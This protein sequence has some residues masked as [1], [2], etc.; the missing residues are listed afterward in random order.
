MIVLNDLYDY[1]LKIYQDTDKF[2]FSL[3]SILIAE[4]VDNSK[5]NR[6]IL[7]LCTG[8]A[9]I[10]LILASYNPTTFITG[11]EIQK[12]IYD[13]AIKSI[14]YNKLE[15]QINLLNINAKDV[16]NYFP[17][18]NFDAILCNPPF[19]KVSSFSHINNNKAKAIARH[20]LTITLKDIFEVSS[21]LLKNGGEFYLVHRPERLEEIIIN[22]FNY[23][24]HVK[25]IEFIYTKKEDYAIM[26][27]L[28]FVKGSNLGVKVS[29]T[30]INNNI[31]YQNIFKNK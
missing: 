13:L 2:K 24:L 21:N 12:E 6:K 4:F 17:G 22:A 28:K 25:K 8:N 3:D 10:P 26:V 7:D 5:N 31:T 29:S 30:L 20:E 9:P 19:F 23:N 14:N 1:G 18:N 27:L 16:K 15:N 11:I